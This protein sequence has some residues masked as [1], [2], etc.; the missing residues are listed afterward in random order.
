[1]PIQSTIGAACDAID[2]ARREGFER[3]EARRAEIGNELLGLEDAELTAR[4]MLDGARSSLRVSQRLRNPD[5][6]AAAEAR[7]AAAEIA[8]RKAEADLMAARRR[9]VV[10]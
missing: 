10:S 5:F 1:M 4:V 9:A 8:W 3:R 7:V 6:I 2:A